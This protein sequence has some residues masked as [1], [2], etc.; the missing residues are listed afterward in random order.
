MYGFSG[1]ATNTYSSLRLPQIFGPDINLLM[2]I[3]QLPPATNI[4]QPKIV[5]QNDYG[6]SIPFTLLDCNGNPVDLTDGSL[7]LKVQS[8]QDP[9]DELVTLTGFMVIDDAD[10]GTCHYEVAAGDFPNPGTFL[11]MVVASWAGSE[12]VSWTGPQLI[13]KAALPRTMN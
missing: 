12:T 7:T 4:L 3:L 2:T 13:V 11:T 10:A 9:T 5:I 1:F 6:Y 8:A